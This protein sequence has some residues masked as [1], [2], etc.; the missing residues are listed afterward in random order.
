VNA[1]PATI[2]GAPAGDFRHVEASPEREADLFLP[3]RSRP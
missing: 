1:R 2:T 3:Y